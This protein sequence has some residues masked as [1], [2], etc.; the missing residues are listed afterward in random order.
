MRSTLLRRCGL[1]AVG[2]LLVPAVPA[3]ASAPGRT[4]CRIDDP[5]I[6]EASGIAARSNGSAGAGYV[7]VQND[8]GDSARFFAI[9]T[10]TGRTA[11]VYDVPGARALDWED[12]AVGSDA[13]GVRSVWLADIGDN[14]AVRAEIDV[15]R[16]PEPARPAYAGASLG[17]PVLDTA[18]PEVW[19][20]R[21][22]DG[23]QDAES[24]AVDP[25]THQVYIATK[26]VFG[27]S[28]VYRLPA[29]PD[30]R[31]RQR[32]VAVGAV[33]FHPHGSG[34]PF[35]GIGQVSATGGTI[36][37]DGRLFVLRTYSQ[38]YVWRLHDGDVAAA[39]RTAP[40]RVALPAQPQGEGV[41]VVGAELWLSSE[42]TDSAIRTVALPAVVFAAPRISTPV[43]GRPARIARSRN[44]ADPSW[45]ALGA[46]GAL[47]V[48]TGW[49]L[50]RRCRARLPRR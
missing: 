44:R 48:A 25:V 16:V 1:I 22:P 50:A 18:R 27:T 7:Y 41:A 37:A 6:T 8:S 9:D 2:I 10:H 31:M 34:G 4:V 30:P 46:G 17:A 49:V 23:P 29:R 40:I 35:G 3:A 11:A 20:L 13:A 14:D 19:R 32:L 24:I 21:Y 15:Y 26:S 33:T 12:I 45:W 5:R 36:S 42:S 43:A 38:A 28:S 39:L 47:A